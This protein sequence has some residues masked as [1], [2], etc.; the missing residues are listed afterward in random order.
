MTAGVLVAAALAMGAVVV[1][2][3][4]GPHR[5]GEVVAA[6]RRQH[7]RAEQ[8]QGS[9][10]PGPAQGPG[11]VA[12]RVA[13]AV[14]ALA[15]WLFVG[16]VAGLLLAVVTAAVGPRILARLEPKGARVR[17]QRMEAAAPGVA[18]LLAAC[19]AAGTPMQS[20]LA[21]VGEATGQPAADV[22]KQAV[23]QLE[24]GADPDAVW[25]AMGRHPALAPIA[26][27]ARRS[28]ESG[29]PL[30]EVLCRVAD[31]LRHSHRATV[32]K[33]ARSVGVRAVGPLGACFLPAFMLLGVVP[34]VASLLQHVLP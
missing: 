3:Q 14:A 13:A 15:V 16:G 19:L 9:R 20:A 31:D 24:L 27:A 8:A 32:E 11:V 17:R 6:L 22:L 34:L 33:A 25:A 23:G 2:G 28:D 21:A 5:G 26:R 30:A 4:S 7:E 29:A 10:R 12:Q 1:A 18:D